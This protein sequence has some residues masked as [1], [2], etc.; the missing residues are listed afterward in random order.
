MKRKLLDAFLMGALIITIAFSI[1]SFSLYLALPGEE[2][3]RSVILVEPQPEQAFYERLQKAPHSVMKDIP[4]EQT[5]PQQ[6]AV[7]QLP[8]EPATKDESTEEKPE[9]ITGANPALMRNTLTRF[10]S[11]R[12]PGIANPS[13]PENRALV[14][15]MVKKQLAESSPSQPTE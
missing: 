10:D 14:K 11:L 15:S 4:S 6:V 5:K 8:E 2:K 13:S 1:V 12:Q 7:A 3:A 9:R